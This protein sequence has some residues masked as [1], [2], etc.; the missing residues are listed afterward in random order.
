M[1]DAKPSEIVPAP[2]PRHD[3]LATRIN[4]AH[5][6]VKN[7]IRRGAEHAIKAGDLLLQAKETVGHGVFLEWLGEHCTC[8][9]RTAQLYMKL[10]KEKDKLGSN[11]KSISHLTLTEAMEMLGPLKQKL[12]EKSGAPQK[13]DPITEAITK[14]ALGILRRAWD[15]AGEPQRKMFVRTYIKPESTAPPS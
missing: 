7:S 8:T 2:T 14:D 12:G 9:P 10:A 6:E 4:A 5:E 1:P 3:D 13:R 15:A 11:T